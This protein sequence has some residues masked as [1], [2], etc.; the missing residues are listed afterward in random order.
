MF[1]YNIALIVCVYMLKGNF[2]L[3]ATTNNLTAKLTVQ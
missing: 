3:L 1:N 2:N